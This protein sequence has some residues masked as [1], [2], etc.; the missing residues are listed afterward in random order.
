MLGVPAGSVLLR[1]PVSPE[2][3]GK[4]R[5]HITPACAAD[6]FVLLY[7][8]LLELTIGV[9]ICTQPSGLH[10]TQI[11]ECERLIIA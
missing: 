6:I 3:I 9:E 11:Y 5:A 7:A 10:K 2:A 4:R 1:G 8:F